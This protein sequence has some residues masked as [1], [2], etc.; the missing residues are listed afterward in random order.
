MNR[1]TFLSL[2]ALSLAGMFFSPLWAKRA[3]GGRKY[4]VLV[5]GD[6]HF[7]TEPDTVYHANYVPVN[8]RL[9][10]IQRA[11]FK[12]NGE[13]WRERCPRLVARAS[14]LIDKHTRFVYQAGDLIQG[15]CGSGEVHRKMLDDVMN[16]FKSQFKGLPFVTVEGNHDIRGPQANETYEAYMP[17]RMSQELGQDIRKTTFSFWQGPDV[18]I[19]VN[20]NHPDDE[21]FE[22]LLAESQ[23]ARYTFV[24][25]H[26]ALFPMDSKSCRWMFHGAPSHAEKRRHFR[27]LLAQRNA[28]CLCGHTHTTE[29]Y[30]WYGDGGRLTQVTVSSVFTDE[31]KGRYKIHIEGPENYGKLRERAFQKDADYVDETPLYDEY[32]EGLKT[33]TYSYAVGSYKLNVSDRG[34]TLDFY[35]GDSEEVSH[36]F[37]LR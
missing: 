5:L 27:R 20:F 3:K 25:I 26:A 36:T 29:F 1:R 23:H 9:N 34:V 4:S 30:D 28:I 33:W 21:E 19:V 6:T 31:D 17:A 8:E 7:D 13:M 24:L 22:R 14:R 10:V 16:Y 11:E 18:Y 32:R 35:A 2:S 15:D 37:V 12:R